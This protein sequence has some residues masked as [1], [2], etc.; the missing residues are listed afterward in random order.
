M[1]IVLLF[2]TEHIS[3][4]G[5]LL[6]DDRIAVGENFQIYAHPVGHTRFF[7][8]SQYEDVWLSVVLNSKTT[9]L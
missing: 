9:P 7:V 3:L 1:L 5:G 8:Y 4:K 2:L 6:E